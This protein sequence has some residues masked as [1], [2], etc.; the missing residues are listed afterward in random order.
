M[1]GGRYRER[2]SASR[3]RVLELEEGQG[4]VHR[5]VR[6][7]GREVP[8]IQSEKAVDLPVQ[9]IRYVREEVLLE[10]RIVRSQ[11]FWR[12]VWRRVRCKLGAS[13]QGG[14]MGPRLS[15]YFQNTCCVSN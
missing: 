6:E 9:Y 1:G 10:E 3:G 8:C 11:A 12:L 13:C 7:E 5:C 4:V 2:R 15:C 14:M